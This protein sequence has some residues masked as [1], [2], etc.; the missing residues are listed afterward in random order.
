MKKYLIFT[1]A[2]F[3]FCNVHAVTEKYSEWSSEYPKGVNALLIR[4]EDRY[5]WYRDVITD[6]EFIMKELVK[7]KIIDYNDIVYKKSEETII[8]PEA[9][10]SR[11][12]H[13][14]NKNYTFKKN[15]I[16]SISIKFNDTNVYELEIY[17]SDEKYNYDIN[18]EYKFLNDNDYD[19]YKN[20][21]TNIDI[22]LNDKYDIDDI[23]IKLYYDNNSS[24]YIAFKSY[25]YDV[26]YNDFNLDSD[27]LVV[28]S[29]NLKSKLVQNIP[30]YKYRDM[31]YRTYKMTREYTKEYYS[32]YDSDYTKDESTKKEFYSYLL[33]DY[34]IVDS[35]G[36]IVKNMDYCI[37]NFCSIEIIEEKEEE[38]PK[39]GDF[40]GYS[41]ILL[42]ISFVI[43]SVMLFIFYKKIVSKKSSFV[44]SL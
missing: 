26:F 16:D 39:T 35:K 25:I 1:I 10:I 20:I 42:F 22:K 9:F 43:I 33:N 30:I 34:V 41:F 40:I 28:D 37:K 32:E 19:V 5:L 8:R 13:I 38:N 36:N 2:L 11:V 6:E 4:K 14:E 7:D 29:S 44:E 18:E 21:N 31:L 17:I 27:V 3:L 15:D 12:I 23:V 24:V